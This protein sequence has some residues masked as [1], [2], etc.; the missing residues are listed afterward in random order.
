MRRN[1]RKVAWTKAH[2]KLRGKEMVNDSTLEFSKKRNRPIK[3]DRDVWDSTLR[4]MKRIE[5]IKMRR[6]E[7]FYKQRMKGNKKQKY[8]DAQKEIQRDKSMVIST[9]AEKKQQQAA[10]SSAPSRIDMITQSEL[11]QSPAATSTNKKKST[12]VQAKNR[13]QKSSKMNIDG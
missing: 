5:E 10:S 11:A 4:A 6:Q 13:T 3:Y 8:L 7:D 1:P 2:R 9:L 12:R